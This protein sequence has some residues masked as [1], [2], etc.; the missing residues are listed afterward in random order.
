M[1]LLQKGKP[2]TGNYH[3]LVPESLC[4][5]KSSCGQWKFSLKKDYRISHSMK[6]KPFAPLLPT[7][8]AEYIL[9]ETKQVCQDLCKQS[10]PFT[11]NKQIFTWAIES[12]NRNIYCLLSSVQWEEWG[13]RSYC[14]NIS[15]AE[16]FFSFE[17]VRRY[18]CNARVIIRLLFWPGS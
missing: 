6:K 17:H 13:V 3:A 9:T 4:N 2:K 14:F 11:N 5:I 18:A 16:L 8:L 10:Y 12:H 1:Y 15:R 7:E